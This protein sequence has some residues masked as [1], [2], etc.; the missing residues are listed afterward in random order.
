MGS[1]V[2]ITAVFM[3]VF[4]V[5]AIMFREI[6][7]MTRLGRST[8]GLANFETFG[9]T[10]LMLI[11]MTTGENWDFV[12]HDMMVEAPN[13]TPNKESYLDND[14]GSRAWAYFM[15]LSFYIVCTYILL[16]MFIAVIISNFSFAY[17]HDT[18]TTL[19]TREDLRNFKLTWA[20]FD[21]RGTGYIDPKYLSQFLRSL[22]GRLCTRVYPNLEFSIPTLIKTHAT[23]SLGAGGLGSGPAGASG[24]R[25]TSATDRPNNGAPSS[26]VL[27]SVQPPS[28]GSNNRLN[29]MSVS[30]RFSATSVSHRRSSAGGM[31]ASPG[32]VPITIS[33]PE[34]G[35]TDEK[36]PGELQV[37]LDLYHLQQTLSKIDVFDAHRRRHTYNLI[38]KEAMATC[39]ERGIS[40]YSILDILSFTLVDVEQALG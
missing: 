22:D 16:N 38:Y 1:I 30:H 20:K 25:R 29:R 23:G 33:G 39:G 2:N 32:G 11:R 8:S 14:C 19:I 21:P 36:K 15:F 35:D 7:G 27:S 28:N 9:N 17:Q 34:S 3:V 12:M 5:Y 24:Q 6:F 31:G 37:N 13:C 10:M 40:F 26:P 18:I 4:T